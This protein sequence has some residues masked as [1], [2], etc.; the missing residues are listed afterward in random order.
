MHMT[1]AFERIRHAV[2]EER[3]ATV[4]QIGPL[5]LCAILAR[6]YPLAS[7]AS[8][9]LVVGQARIAADRA[10]VLRQVKGQYGV[11]RNGRVPGARDAERLDLL[12]AGKTLVPQHLDDTWAPA[13]KPLRAS[14][15]AG[16][17]LVIAVPGEP[18]LT[19]L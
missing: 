11:P 2:R 13:E 15:E 1:K 8:V 5:E 6:R 16:I 10:C 14:V 19:L 18:A 3:E 7:P 17:G 12:L 4:H 9:A